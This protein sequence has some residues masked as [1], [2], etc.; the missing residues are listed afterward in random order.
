MA[1]KNQ[2]LNA[3]NLKDVL[4]D[5]L[6]KVKSGEIEAGQADSIA[7]QAREILRTVNTQLKVCSQSKRSVPQEVIH[8]SENTQ[9]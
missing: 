3:Q 1:T 8:F 9:K 2:K 4:W 6:T 5:T 7:T